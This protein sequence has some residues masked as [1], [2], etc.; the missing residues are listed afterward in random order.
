M[1]MN[2]DRDSPLY[3]DGEIISPA[4]ATMAATNGV[5]S[6]QHAKGNREAIGVRPRFRASS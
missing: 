4:S 5:I 2:P 1:A 3:R 6:L